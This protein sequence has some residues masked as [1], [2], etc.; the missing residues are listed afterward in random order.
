MKVED[1]EKSVL[2][3][4]FQGVGKQ[5]H[6]KDVTAVLMQDGWHEIYPGTFKLL[7]TPNQVPFVKFEMSMWDNNEAHIIE[8]FPNSLYG[9]AYKKP[10]LPPE[11]FDV[12]VDGD[13]DE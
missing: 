3:T 9:V 11:R 4:S 6:N 10:V 1:T 7:K 13:G 8:I 12:D 5:V 2:Q